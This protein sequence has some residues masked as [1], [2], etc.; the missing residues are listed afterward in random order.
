MK[1][2]QFKTLIR[3]E[4]TKVLKEDAS[5]KESI[6]ELFEVPPAEALEMLTRI[7]YLAG[8]G[9][10]FISIYLAMWT[11]RTWLFSGE[12]GKNVSDK[13]KQIV[14]DYKDKKKINPD[15]LKA[16]EQ[17]VLANIN[18]LPAGKQK[19]I[20]SLINKIHNT[21]IEDKGTVLKLKRNVE[22]SMKDY[23]INK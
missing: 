7:G 6:N 1:L 19:F 11:N 13:F 15:D 8:V 2:S 12:F 22:D 20:K 17:E 23:N 18:Q 10:I 9:G 4:V 3:E 16:F 21:N 14:Q 5:T